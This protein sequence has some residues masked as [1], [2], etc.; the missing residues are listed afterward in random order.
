MGQISQTLIIF[1]YLL[2]IL[3]SLMF[4]SLTKKLEYETNKINKI[5]STNQSKQI[6]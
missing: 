2:F 1:N 5:A 4:E 6:R 3:Y